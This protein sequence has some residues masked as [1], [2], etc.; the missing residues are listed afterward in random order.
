MYDFN[1]LPRLIKESEALSD[2]EK[3]K[4]TLALPQMPDSQKAEL[5]DI[6]KNEQE[7]RYAINQNLNAQRKEYETKR[8]KV[9]Y[10]YIERKV[11]EEEES[12]LEDIDNEL[13]LID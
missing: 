8:A 12:T 7:Q 11:G 3:R 13:A 9:I 4:L 2:E 1:L 6:L 10:S 5:Y